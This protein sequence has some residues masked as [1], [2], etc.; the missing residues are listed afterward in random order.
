MQSSVKCFNATFKITK[1]LFTPLRLCWQLL[2]LPI[3]CAIIQVWIHIEAFKLFAKGVTFI[4]HPEGAETSMSKAIGAIMAPFFAAK[5]WFE[6]IGKGD[7]TTL[8]TKKV[9]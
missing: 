3:F 5:D 4:D 6:T 7:N 8:K 9:S 2:R 1:Q